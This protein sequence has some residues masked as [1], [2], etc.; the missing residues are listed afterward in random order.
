M[1]YDFFI[2]VVATFFLAGLTFYL[3][4]FLTKIFPFRLRWLIF[5]NFTIYLYLS[6]ESSFYSEINSTEEGWFLYFFMMAVTTTAITGEYYSRYRVFHFFH[7]FCRF[8]IIFI[9]YY[10]AYAIFFYYKNLE[11]SGTSCIQEALTFNFFG[12]LSSIEFQRENRRLFT[13]CW[14][15]IYQINH[16]E[17]HLYFKVFFISPALYFLAYIY[18]RKSH[19]PKKLS[20]TQ[21]ASRFLD[22]NYKRN[23]DSADIFLKN[24]ERKKYLD[25]VFIVIKSKPIKGEGEWVYVNY[26][27]KPFKSI[28]LIIGDK[29]NI[30]IKTKE[31]R[32][33]Y[34]KT[35]THKTTMEGGHSYGTSSSGEIISIYSAPKEVT[36]SVGTGKYESYGTGKYVFTI[37]FVKDDTNYIVYNREGLEKKIVDEIEEVINAINIYPQNV[38][39]AAVEAAKEK[40]EIESQERQKVKDKI[41]LLTREKAEKNR[42]AELNSAGFNQLN[43]LTFYDYFYDENGE[44]L[45]L[46]AADRNG[47]GLIFIVENKKATRW[48]GSWK[49]ATAKIEN[50]HVNFMVVDDD[51]R[52]EHLTERRFRLLLN[53]HF[54]T[55]EK[56]VDRI[57]LLQNPQ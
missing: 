18:Y 35:V 49:G 54:T 57:R 9:I 27:K 37:S 43:E 53:A 14:P 25:D 26:S 21:Y 40:R 20:E 32:K 41:I 11:W 7:A 5:L 31:E 17:N 36:T 2:A 30:D 29:K 34:E 42:D 10:I 38:I 1:N 48:I 12:L 8:V 16:P 55:R 22:I 45:E 50:N 6:P 19:A 44:L 56:W 23:E 15:I 46:I 3:P 51:Y 13:K 24:R 52:A 39:N 33:S 28:P 47:K 4:E